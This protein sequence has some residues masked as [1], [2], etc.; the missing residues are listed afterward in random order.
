MQGSSIQKNEMYSEVR[1]LQLIIEAM[2]SGHITHATSP[3]L[4]QDRDSNPSAHHME[5][6]PIALLMVNVKSS[7]SSAQGL[8]QF[9]CDTDTA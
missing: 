7:I 3:K 6:V 8:S 1:M 4:I 2:L 9:I 5:L